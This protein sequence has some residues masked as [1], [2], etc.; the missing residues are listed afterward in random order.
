MYRGQLLAW[1]QWLLYKFR[2]LNIR[3]ALW[4]GIYSHMET[5]AK[6]VLPGHVIKVRYHHS[7]ATTAQQVST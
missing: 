6:R 2:V 1:Y 3:V 4:A 7:I 5:K